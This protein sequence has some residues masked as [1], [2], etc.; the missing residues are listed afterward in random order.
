MF[1]E[2]QSGTGSP[3]SVAIEARVNNLTWSDSDYITKGLEV[4]LSNTN[5][6]HNVIMPY[7]ISSS[8]Y[9]GANTV[10]LIFKNLT[11]GAAIT[12]PADGLVFSAHAI[13]VL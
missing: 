3:I 7:G 5:L 13:P 6:T 12:N 10:Y 4:I 2:A 9:T 1:F 11:S 8:T